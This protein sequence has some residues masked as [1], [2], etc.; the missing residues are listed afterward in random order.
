MHH[1]QP[2][3]SGDWTSEEFEYYGAQLLSLLKRHFD[4]IRHLPVSTSISPAELHQLLDQPL[5][6]QA[7]P[8]SETLQET[9][10]HVIPHLTHWNHPSFHAYFSNSAS[11]PG[12]LA[13]LLIS[14]L[15]VNA[16]VWKSAPAASTLEKVVLKWLAEMIKLDP[17]TDGVLLNGAS[18]ATFYALV[19]ARDL[20]APIDIDIRNEGLIGHTNL[21]KMR[22]YTSDQ[23]HSSVDKAAIALGIGLNNVVKISSNENYQMIP[24]ELKKALEHDLKQGYLPIA[25]IA[26]VGTTSTGAVDPIQPIAKLCRKH[27][28]WLHIDAAYGGFWNLVPEIE[29]HAEDLS[30]G[31]SLVVNPHKV[32]YT[33]LEVTALFCKRKNALANSFRLVPE[34]LETTKED[35]STDYMDYSLQLGRSFRSLKLW[36]VIRTFGKDG[37]AKQL[38]HS[39]DLT[40]WL[41]AEI[42]DHP[43]FIQI[44]SSP[45]ALICLRV[46]PRKIQ[47]FLPTATPEERAL[48][49]GYIDQLNRA[50]LEKLNQTGTT[51]LSHT[52]VKQGYVIRIS[53]GNIHTEFRDIERLWELLKK[54]SGETIQQLTLPSFVD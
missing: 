1:F 41:S 39:I 30:L 6:E 7:L 27:G 9:W 15:N 43:D 47:A 5:P 2:N 17:A 52:V 10:D 49:G 25:V 38:T 29:M 20:H 26:T 51:F 35:G 54:I 44:A 12:I 11:Y 32:L 14:S 4:H 33:P 34:Y 24:T 19:A 18:L 50:I 3:K 23:A 36:W 16:M 22:I 13:D 53:I 40:K 21:P 8:F 46:I 37:L 42:A 31:D 28:V 45:F 48:L